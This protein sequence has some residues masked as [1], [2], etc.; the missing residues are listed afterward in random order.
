MCEMVSTVF[1]VAG[2]GVGGELFTSRNV[3][4]M[5]TLH[6]NILL[7]SHKYSMCSQYH[8]KSN[9]NAKQKGLTRFMKICTISIP[10]VGKKHWEYSCC[11]QVLFP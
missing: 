11:D 4:S 5:M 7:L 6:Q 10:I 8:F 2:A 3:L 1:D 9:F